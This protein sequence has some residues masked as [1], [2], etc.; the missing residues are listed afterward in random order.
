MKA[1]IY[2]LISFLMFF[3]VFLSS[4]TACENGSELDTCAPLISVDSEVVTGF[5]S[6]SNVTLKC[7]WVCPGD[8][9]VLEGAVECNIFLEPKASL[10]IAGNGNFI[11][12]KSEAKVDVSAGAFNTNVEILEDVIYN[13]DGINTSTMI[14]SSIDFDYMFAPEDGCDLTSSQSDLAEFTVQ[15]FPN[16]VS[17]NTSVFLSARESI[18]GELYLSDSFGRVV[19]KWKIDG[20][21][22]IDLPLENTSPGI[23]LMHI[24]NTTFAKKIVV[25]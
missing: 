21:S 1:L 4:Q 22:T 9:L 24:P 13:D 14:C 18:F 7:Y 11:W 17:Q 20:Q 5:K 25:F 2:T 12:G 19:K 16:P 23:Y 10:I 15:I 6:Y 8:S 3:P